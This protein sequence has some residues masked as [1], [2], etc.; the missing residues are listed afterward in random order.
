MSMERAQLSKKL[1][2]LLRK[3]QMC[4]IFKTVQVNAFGRETHRLLM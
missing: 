3:A 1:T 2:R 4:F